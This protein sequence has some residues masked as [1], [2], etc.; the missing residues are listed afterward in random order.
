ML[1]DFLQ[2]VIGQYLSAAGHLLFPLYR[3]APAEEEGQGG[4]GGV[5]SD[6]VHPQFPAVGLQ[7]VTQ[8]CGCLLYTSDAADE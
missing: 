3:I 8:D 7:R 4:L 2:S 5:D 6:G 1:Q